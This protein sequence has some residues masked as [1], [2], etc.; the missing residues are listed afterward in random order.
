MVWEAIGMQSGLAWLRQSFRAEMVAEEESIE[1]T[2]KGPEFPVKNFSH[3]P[4]GGECSGEPP[5]GFP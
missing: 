2:A 4:E 3:Y 5:K 1:H